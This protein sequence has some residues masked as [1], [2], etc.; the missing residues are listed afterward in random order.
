MDYN[1]LLDFATDLG[2]QLAMSGAE[3]FRVEE[4]INRIMQAYGIAGEVF[5]IP[6]CITVS[7]EADDGRPITRMRRV[8]FHGN[9]LD[10][11]EGYSNLSRLVCQAKPTPETAMEWLKS[12]DHGRRSYSFPVVLMAHYLGAFGFSLFF[13]GTLK[14]C[15]FG[16]VGGLIVGV[17][18]HFM[19]NLK[20]NAFFRIISASFL[21]ALFAYCLAMTP[22]VDNAD[23]AIIGPLMLLVP[24]L[25]FTNAM[26]DIIYGDTN[27][28]VVRIVQVFLT[29][30]AI[31]LGTGAAWHVVT[32]I[33]G[34]P[35]GP[36]V[37]SYNALILNIGCA[38][39]CMGF[40]LLFNIHGPGGVICV[41]GGVLAW[42]VYMLVEQL[43]G[44]DIVAYFWASIAAAFFSETMARLRKYPAIS[45][46][47][48]AIFPLIPGASVYYTMD[49]AV[50][51]DMA[52]FSQIGFHTIAIAGVLAVGILLVSTSFRLWSTWR[53]RQTARRNHS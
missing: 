20:A 7:I 49:R 46:L 12:A 37:Q 36:G 48:V 6:N 22:C 24:G 30:A 51:G 27:S 45:Y 32:S 19:E 21:M 52:G 14:D 33:W 34:Q 3:T 18:D 11:V 8:G 23:V 10:A 15:L 2:Y 39:G 13:G 5:A 50:Q 44:D 25:L 17:V 16:G 43:C 47:V 1:L 31:A 29:A 4:S 53:S 28:G 38:I 42:S 35:I 40:A 41:V 26:R 9:D